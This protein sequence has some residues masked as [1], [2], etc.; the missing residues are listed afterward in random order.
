M[1]KLRQR[2]VLRNFGGAFMN[3]NLR[4]ISLVLM[5]MFLFTTFALAADPIR[6][7]TN[8][9]E[10]T[11]DTNP[12][13]QEGRTLVPLRAIFDSLGAK[14]DW[15]AETKTVT[16]ITDTQTVKLTINNK[17]AYINNKRTTLDVP[18]TIINNRTMVPTR[19]IAE[20][21]G[22]SV[23]WH[24]K[25]RSVLVNSDISIVEKKPAEK[26]VETLSQ[27]NAVSKAKDY[28]NYSS[29]SKSGLI[30]Q[31]EYEGFSNGDANYAVAKLNVNWKEQAVNTA[32]DYLDYSSFSKSGL[33]KQL[34][35]EGFS[36]EDANYAASQV[37]F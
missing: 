21:L 13:I 17:T 37:G 6:I 12:V 32:K 25:S 2:I 35:F 4:I 22:A 23:V 28:I 15:N 33:I 29:F 7:Y 27:K 10:L 34:E 24:N 26:Q 20:S 31:L 16:G 14:V 3:K 11:L 1:L 18:A 36:S 9:K 5:F 8:N 19:F 30:K